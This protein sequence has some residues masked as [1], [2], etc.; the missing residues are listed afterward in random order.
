M[1][2]QKHVLLH[3]A[4][5][6]G[7]RPPYT[8]L[9]E[10]L[11]R[12]TNSLQLMRICFSVDG[13][14]VKA[15]LAADLQLTGEVAHAFNGEAVHCSASNDIYSYIYTHTHKLPSDKRWRNYVP[16]RFSCSLTPRLSEVTRCIV[17]AL[18]AE[19]NQRA[20]KFVRK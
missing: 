6:F 14:F 13:E 11:G 17:A 16:A 8:V 15:V 18:K 1:K 19:A 12:R 3:A 10:R 20:F 2:Q 7:V 5:N 9:G 4:V